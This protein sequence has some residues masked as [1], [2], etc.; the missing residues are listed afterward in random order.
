MRE[1]NKGEKEEGAGVRGELLQ[2]L[3]LPGTTTAMAGSARVAALLREELLQRLLPSYLSPRCWRRDKR[4]GGGDWFTGEERDWVGV[5]EREAAL[6]FFDLGFSSRD[7]IIDR[8]ELRRGENLLSQ[9]RGPTV[10]LS[11]LS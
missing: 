5:G 11:Q 10:T 3:L 2:S 8:N 9:I 6:I 7:V 1:R 4:E